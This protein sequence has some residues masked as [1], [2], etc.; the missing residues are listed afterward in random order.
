MRQYTPVNSKNGGESFAAVLLLLGAV[1]LGLLG[2]VRGSI[3]DEELTKHRE[4]DITEYKDR[5][6]KLFDQLSYTEQSI[7]KQINSLPSSTDFDRE[8]QHLLNTEVWRD[9]SVT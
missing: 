7:V 2:T 1:S 5:N 4:Q 3:P 8:I 6:R 9:K